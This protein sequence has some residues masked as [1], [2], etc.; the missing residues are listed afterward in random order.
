MEA[1]GEGDEPGYHGYINDPSWHLLYP[2]GFFRFLLASVLGSL[3]NYYLKNGIDP[4]E[5]VKDSSAW[6]RGG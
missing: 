3:E 1:F 6:S 2:G 4:Y 5:R